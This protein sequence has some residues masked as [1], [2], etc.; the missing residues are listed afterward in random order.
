MIETKWTEFTL[1]EDAAAI[2]RAVF[3]REQ[4]IREC[5]EF[6]DKETLSQHLVVYDGDRAVAAGRLTLSGTTARLGRIAVLPE[7]RKKGMG[8]LVVKLL[9]FRAVNQGAQRLEILAQT[10]AAGF[11]R[12]Y[13]FTAE[14]EETMADGLPHIMMTNDPAHCLY[15]SKCRGHA[16]ENT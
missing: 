9:M 14:G 13:G 16:Q 3:V 4:G 6:D 10:H 11:Y 7:A 1:P 12:R 15:P 2:R 8:D 5:D